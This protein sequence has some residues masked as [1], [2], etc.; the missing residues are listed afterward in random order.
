[1]KRK[2]NGWVIY[3][4]SRSEIRKISCLGD[5]IYKL[6]VM[7]LP[8]RN[9]CINTYIKKE[10]FLR[11]YIHWATVYKYN[12]KHIGEPD[13]RLKAELSLYFL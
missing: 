11:H 13:N 4:N 8:E 2:D 5:G 3:V 12:W 6:I 9:I 10:Q 7:N 1:M